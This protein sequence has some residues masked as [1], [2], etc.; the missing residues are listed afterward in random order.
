M[1][2]I[3]F[4]HSCMETI[5]AIAV[6][7]KGSSLLVS[8]TGTSTDMHGGLSPCRDLAVTANPGGGTFHLQG[9]T[10]DVLAIQVVV[11]GLDLPTLQAAMKEPWM[12]ALLFWLWLCS[13]D[14][15]GCAGLDV[16][17]DV[18]FTQC[19]G[20]SSPKIL[21]SMNV[22]RGSIVS[23]SSHTYSANWCGLP[24]IGGWAFSAQCCNA[25]A[26]ARVFC[27]CFM[28]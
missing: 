1:P 23:L 28:Q 24:G 20:T 10:R 17:E 6:P 21:A 16:L 2:D 14:V 8:S 3:T 4:C 25:L 13:L 19:K 22:T 5:V 11:M 26:Y 15:V 18:I 27:C 9:G 7:A 12:W